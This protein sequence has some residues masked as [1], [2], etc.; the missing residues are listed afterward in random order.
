MEENLGGNKYKTSILAKKWPVFKLTFWNSTY[1]NDAQHI[2]NYEIKNVDRKW[3][4]G[5]EIKIK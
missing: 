4:I 1:L 2:I 5:D 3:K